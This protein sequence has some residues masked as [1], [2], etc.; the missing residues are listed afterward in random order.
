MFPRK[1]KTLDYLDILADT[2]R[3]EF[4][5]PIKAVWSNLFVPSREPPAN[6]Q[7]DVHIPIHPIVEDIDVEVN[8]KE[9][10]EEGTH[11]CQIILM[12]SWGTQ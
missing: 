3:K 10:V 12:E 2:E 9:D 11:K 6:E 4:T 7:D 1:T 8:T 5:S